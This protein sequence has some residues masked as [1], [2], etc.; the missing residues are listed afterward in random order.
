LLFIDDFI[1]TVLGE[2]F[3]ISKAGTVAEAFALSDNKTPIVL[4]HA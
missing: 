2:Y 1:A 3:L 4:V